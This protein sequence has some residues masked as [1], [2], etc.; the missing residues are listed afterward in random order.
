MLRKWLWGLRGK[1][2]VSVSAYLKKLSINR[3]DLIKHVPD[4]EIDIDSPVNAYITLAI[5]LK[6]KGEYYKSLKILERLK[7]ENLPENER[8]L[9]YLNLAL[10][11]RA[12]GF[13]DRAEDA[14]REG[15]SLFPSESFFYYE[16]AQICKVSGRLEEAVELLEKAVELRREFEDE[17]IYTKLYLADSYIDR[18]RTDKAFRLIRKL[19]IRFPVPLFYYITAKLHYAVGEAERGYRRALQGMKLS[20]GHV[21]PFLKVIEEYEGLTTEKLEEIM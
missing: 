18:G 19:D 1:N 20:P 2:S 15:I 7:R 13:L 3:H 11:Y 6:E 10:T 17:L 21:L 12:A 14:L 16:L 9:L 4:A 5:L 8:R